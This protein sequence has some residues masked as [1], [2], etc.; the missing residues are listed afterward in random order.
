MPVPWHE[1]D[2]Q[3]ETRW[4]RAKILRGGSLGTVGA[5][6]LRRVCSLSPWSA[7]ERVLDRASTWR[8]DDR[9]DRGSGLLRLQGRRSNVGG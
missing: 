3:N 5:Q 2:S 8:V 4:Q 7:C 6:P 1:R 9:E